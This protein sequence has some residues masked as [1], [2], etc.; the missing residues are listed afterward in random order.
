[1]LSFKLMC[2]M[3]DVVQVETLR[4]DG[5]AVILGR[6]LDLLALEVQ[7]RMI[8]AVMA[9]LQLVRL[10]AQSQAQNLMAEADAEDRLLTEQIAGHS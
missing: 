3:F 4:V 1:M 7:H 8:A 6:D 5:E 2:V 10:A 9:E